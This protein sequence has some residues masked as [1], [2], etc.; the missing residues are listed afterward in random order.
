[1]LQKNTLSV[2]DLSEASGDQYV[3]LIASKQDLNFYVA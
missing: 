3:V 2:D 1:M